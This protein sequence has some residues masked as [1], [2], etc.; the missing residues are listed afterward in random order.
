MNYHWLTYRDVHCA[1][2]ALSNELDQPAGT[3]VVVA[4]PLSPLFYLA[5]YAC[6]LAGL[7]PVL[8]TGGCLTQL[9]AVLDQL[10]AGSAVLMPKTSPVPQ[11]SRL[12][13][14]VTVITLIVEEDLPRLLSTQ[15]CKLG[16]RLASPPDATA[17]LL[18][19]SGT[20]GAP[21]LTIVTHAMIRQQVRTP[22][23]GTLL[24]MLSHQPFRQSFDILVSLRFLVLSC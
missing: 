20:S 5:H 23:H 12:F 1:S 11:G 4:L 13:S 22:D 24:V 16:G 3:H 9:G 2:V 21:K 19:T 7:I 14:S 17:M 18:P 15:L 10:P 6:L 8:M